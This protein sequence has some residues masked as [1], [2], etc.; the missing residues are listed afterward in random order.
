MKI[1][2]TGAAGF[3]GSHLVDRLIEE[4]HFVAGIDDLSLGRE[5]NLESAREK[6]GE[7]FVFYKADIL[8]RKKLGEIF[9]KHKFDSVFH[10]AANSDISKGI[11]DT[12]RDLEK[13]FMTTYRV[14]DCMKEYKVKN[15]VFASTSAIYGENYNSL[16][17]DT[18]PLMPISF[19]GAAKL[20]SEAYISAYTSC[21]GIKALIVRF[22]NVVGERATHGAM[23]DFIKRLRENPAELT[24]LGDG[25]QI[26]PYLYVKDLIEGILFAWEKTKT[27]IEVYN[28]GVDSATTV[29]TIANIVVEEMNLK[30]VKFKY[31]G[32]DRGWVGDVPTFK[33][34][35]TKI[36]KLGWTAEKTS[37]EAVRC[38]VKAELDLI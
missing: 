26:K 28:I 35:L 22:P 31:T 21:Y 12:E 2:V 13:T 3:I 11:E 37:D 6:G 25:K 9:E 8:D 10:F 29:T 32:G 17:E 30:N 14:L 4:G 23:F 24:V 16:S 33:Y 5:E 36:K 19:Y 27:Q 18:G 20:A 1:L 7:K 15:L 34:D 38:A